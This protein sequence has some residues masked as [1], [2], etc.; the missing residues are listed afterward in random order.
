MF[1]IHN[2]IFL[3]FFIKIKYK[4]IQKLTYTSRNN[5]IYPKILSLIK[6][7]YL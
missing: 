3:Y 2:L 6:E 1:F 5:I 7:N 4:L